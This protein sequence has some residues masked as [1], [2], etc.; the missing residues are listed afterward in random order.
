MGTTNT[1]VSELFTVRQAAS[2]LN[3]SE[4]SIWYHAKNNLHP[5]PLQKGRNILLTRE[6]LITL[7]TEHIRLKKGESSKDELLQRVTKAIAT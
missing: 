6:Q 7:V 5:Q 1:P 3:R 4:Y 2:L